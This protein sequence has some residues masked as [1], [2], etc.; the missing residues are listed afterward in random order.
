M[1]SLINFAIYFPRQK[2]VQS[3]SKSYYSLQVNF[4]IT[5]FDF[6]D[7]SYTTILII[8]KAKVSCKKDKI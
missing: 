1:Y 6:K 3:I 7:F 8:L 2:F 4:I 5:K